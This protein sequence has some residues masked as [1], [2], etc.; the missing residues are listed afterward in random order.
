[1][2]VSL[3]EHFNTVVFSADSR[4]FYKEM[5]IGTAKPSAAEMKD[6]KHYFIDSHS[7][8]DE[9][10]VAKYVKLATPLLLSEFEEHD[11][12]ILTGGSGMFIDALCFG[13]DETPHSLELRK[14]LTT[15]VEKNGTS[16][17]LNEIQLKDPE[18]YEKL[19][20]NNPVRIIRAIEVMRLSGKK[21][22][23]LRKNTIKKQ[24][25]TIHY[26]V[27][28]HNRE[29]LYDRINQRVEIMLNEG[30]EEEVKSLIPYKELSTMRT[31]GYSELFDYFEGKQSKDE[32]IESIKQNS[33][34]Y[35]KR[36]LTWF[37]RHEDAVW[38]PFSSNETMQQNIINC[39]LER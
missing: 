21:F 20:K 6:V 32:A 4:Q 1:M 16:E 17:L 34:R 10:S 3:A 28:D 22:S 25:F 37:R 29:I 24:P 12:I 26:F 19:D 5:S 33:R 9:I 7:I 15:H 18:F 39:I 27:I 13:L 30:L 14:E 31:V 38:I 36:Q 35:A 11:T 23:E 2:S 8:Q